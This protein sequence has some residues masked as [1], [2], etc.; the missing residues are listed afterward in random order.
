MNLEKDETQKMERSYNNATD[1]APARGRPKKSKFEDGS[2]EESA[3]LSPGDFT[4]ASTATPEKVGPG[5]HGPG[6]DAG[7]E[8]AQGTVAPESSGALKNSMFDPCNSIMNKLFE[9]NAMGAAK[10]TTSLEFFKF[11]DTTQNLETPDQ[12]LFLSEKDG[13]FATK[14]EQQSKS[15]DIYSKTPYMQD[16]STKSKLGELLAKAQAI[17]QCHKDTAP[18]NYSVNFNVINSEAPD[19]QPASNG[20]SATANQPNT[21]SWLSENIGMAGMGAYTPPPYVAEPS[22]K[23]ENQYRGEQQNVNT[24]VGKEASST[25]TMQ[26]FNR[27]VGA[28]AEKR[29][30]F[31]AEFLADLYMRP[32]SGTGQEYPIQRTNQS[33]G[34]A[35]PKI[36]MLTQ[37]HYPL[38]PKGHVLNQGQYVPKQEQY[39]TSQGQYMPGQ[40]IPPQGQYAYNHEQY[41]MEQAGQK[42]NNPQ[43]QDE[44]INNLLQVLNSKGYSNFAERLNYN[45]AELRQPQPSSRAPG[46]M[47]DGHMMMP[48]HTPGY[49]TNLGHLY[50]QP[51]DLGSACMLYSSRKKRRNNP[52][53]GNASSFKQEHGTAFPPSKFSSLEFVQGS[54]NRKTMINM[55]PK[56]HE[57]SK[58][59]HI[60]P[61]VLESNKILVEEYAAVVRS[62]K[63]TV[64]QLDLNNVTVF[65]LKS[66]MKE[67]GLN[68]AGKKNELIT[69]IKEIYTKAN[70][71]DLNDAGKEQVAVRQPKQFEKEVEYDKYFF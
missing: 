64:A 23:L 21:S 22:T 7:A 24:A 13:S 44:D 48:K 3:L 39:N 34:Q 10:D 38:N 12:S 31:E 16:T 45:Q 15:A 14:A 61:M 35:E 28:G 2:V 17:S 30:S 71:L 19:L 32:Q 40:Y 53:F 49:F 18:N 67:Y 46:S 25:N 50:R 6:K 41:R 51:L 69:H 47:Y 66:L 63:S 60:L 27:F 37:E 8:G 33:G 65:Q 55:E 42:M 5:D 43:P 9:N 26:G 68:H 62:F 1:D 52:G 57:R 11:P 56:Q 29:K 70:S 4:N 20:A 54:N 58:N 36:P 59:N